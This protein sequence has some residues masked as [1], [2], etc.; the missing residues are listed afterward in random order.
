MTCVQEPSAMRLATDN[1]VS[2]RWTAF[3]PVHGF[4]ACKLCITSFV[5]CCAACLD[6][7]LRVVGV[8]AVQVFLFI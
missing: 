4:A 1:F 6:Q 5:A 8:C 2:F 7:I 3:L